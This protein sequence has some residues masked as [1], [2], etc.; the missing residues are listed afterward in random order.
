MTVLIQ[1]ITPNSRIRKLEESHSNRTLETCRDMSENSL[2]PD[3]DFPEEDDSFVVL[4]DKSGNKILANE[5]DEDDME[6]SFSHLYA[7]MIPVENDIDKGEGDN[8]SS[9]ERRKSS[10]SFAEQVDVK[11]IVP[12]KDMVDV[13]DVY[14]QP[15]DYDDILERSYALADRVAE[16]GLRYCTR[17]LETLLVSYDETALEESVCAVLEEQNIQWESGNHCDRAISRVYT[18]ASIDSR[19]EARMRAEADVKAVRGYLKETRKSFSE[20]SL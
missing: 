19:L 16:G 9:A 1:S 18:L 6:R 13:E 17:G 10:I 14:L 2:F 15:E 7:H 3:S 11:P 5:K 12:V 20:L 8:D 4:H